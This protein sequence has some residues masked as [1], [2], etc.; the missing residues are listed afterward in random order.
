MKQCRKCE[1]MR[2]LH[3][4]RT[5]HYKDGRVFVESVCITC[6]TRPI[7][8]K[9][10]ETGVQTKSRPSWDALLKYRPEDVEDVRMLGKNSLRLRTWEPE[11]QSSLV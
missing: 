4:F 8:G 9:K 6:I 7:E 3:E 2:G 5:R 10:K 1:E 11:G